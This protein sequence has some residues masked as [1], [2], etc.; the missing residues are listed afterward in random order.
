[1]Q[2]SIYDDHYPDE[3]YGTIVV[4]FDPGCQ[5]LNSERLLQYARTR[6]TQGSDFDRARRQQEVITAVQDQLV[7]AGGLATLVAR[8][9]VLWAEVSQN[10]RT[11]L[12]FEEA[13]DLA[14]IV[15][16]IERD[17]ITTERGRSRL[18]DL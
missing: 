10:L 4:S 7:S 2:E 13:L 3:G 11:D 1:V 15:S 16:T 9:P 17:A 8:A 5:A 6:A 14:L 12:T 18:C